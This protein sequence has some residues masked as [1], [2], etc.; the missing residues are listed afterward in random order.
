MC[1]VCVFRTRTHVHSFDYYESF[2]M[3]VEQLSVYAMRSI[4]RSSSSTSVNKNKEKCLFLQAI[5]RL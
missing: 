1:V 4:V 5:N 2:L 3:Q